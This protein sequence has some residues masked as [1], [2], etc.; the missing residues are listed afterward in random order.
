MLKIKDSDFKRI[1]I[2]EKSEL[3]TKDSEKKKKRELK[4]YTKTSWKKKDKELSL[5]NVKVKF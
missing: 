2:M 3:K 1:T 5:K 4:E